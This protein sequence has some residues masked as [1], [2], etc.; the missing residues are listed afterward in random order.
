MPRQ[1]AVRKLGGLV[2]VGELQP[3]LRGRS[4]EADQ[5][6]RGAHS[7]QVGVWRS[8]SI[9]VIAA[10]TGRARSRAGCVPGRARRPRAAATG[11]APT[12]ASGRPGELSLVNRVT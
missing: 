8:P 6:V 11:S 1:P 10:R 7:R 12:G 2:A 3:H 9:P 4:Q 5:G